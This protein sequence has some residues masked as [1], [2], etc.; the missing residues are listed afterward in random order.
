MEY[1]RHAKHYYLLIGGITLLG[2]GFA[3]YRLFFTGYGNTLA[4]KTVA[5][6]TLVMHPEDF[7]AG[8]STI[9]TPQYA[10]PELDRQ[11]CAVA[12]VEQWVREPT[13]GR[14]DGRISIGLYPSARSAQ[15]AFSRL[16]NP[17]ILGRIFRTMASESVPNLG[18][19][20]SVQGPSRLGVQYVTFIRCQAVVNMKFPSPPNYDTIFDRNM[21]LA[22]AQKLDQ[23]LQQALCPIQ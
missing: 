16:G 1:M 6:E 21:L 4:S 19:Q 18:E 9:A 20:A 11:T 15:Q 7:P 14:A 5:L 22:Y 2:I 13:A 8:V 3:V 12:Y 10:T 17:P 23:R